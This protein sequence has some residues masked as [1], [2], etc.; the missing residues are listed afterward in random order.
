[1]N[2]SEPSKLE[3]Q[4]LSVLW[5]RG[6]STVR[7]VL[8]VIP[9][10]KARAYTTVLSVLQVM[11]KKGLVSHTSEG[12]AHVYRARV[13]RDEVAAPLLRG[14]VNHV[15]GGSVAGVMQQLLG[16]EKLNAAELEEIKQLIAQQECGQAA[17]GRGGRK[18][19]GET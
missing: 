11:E 15:F 19:K 6:E 3:M 16:G 1:M 14:L 10:G 12:N 17:P 5:K 4:V 7:E 2:Q 18:K 8:E 9:D 13:S